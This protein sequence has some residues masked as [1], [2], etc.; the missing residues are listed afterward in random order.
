MQN[1][2]FK[3]QNEGAAKATILNHLRSKYLRFA[4]CILHFVQLPDK[5]VFVALPGGFGQ[6]RLPPK[7]N[8]YWDE[9][10]MRFKLE[11]MA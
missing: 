3:M 1:R 10:P 5:L 6:K 9:T 4:L 2:K 7:V 8:A 11:F